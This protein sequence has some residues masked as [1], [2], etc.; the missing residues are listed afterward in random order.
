MVLKWS[1]KVR[2]RFLS[3][4]VRALVFLIY[5]IS[6]EENM[7]QIQ[8]LNGSLKGCGLIIFPVPGPMGP[9]ALRVPWNVSNLE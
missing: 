8:N 2:T 3:D 5:R 1:R 6:S 7:R 4:S 9:W